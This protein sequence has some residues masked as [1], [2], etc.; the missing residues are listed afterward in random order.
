VQDEVAQFGVEV[1][2]SVARYIAEDRL[3]YWAEDRLR[4]PDEPADLADL[5][6]QTQSAA[7]VKENAIRQIQ[8]QQAERDKPVDTPQPV[9]V[10]VL[11][12][13]PTKTI[14]DHEQLDGALQALKTRIGHE[15]DEGRTVILG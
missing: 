15:L 11:D 13:L 1:P 14:K 5:H 3:G 6:Y 4:Y 7:Q 10:K 2:D 8:D 12:E 9:Y